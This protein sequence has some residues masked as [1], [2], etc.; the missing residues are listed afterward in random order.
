MEEG[1]EHLICKI[2]GYLSSRIQTAEQH[3][4]RHIRNYPVTIDLNLQDHCNR[5]PEFDDFQYNTE[6]ILGHM[7]EERV[8]SDH[9]QD[10]FEL[11]ADCESEVSDHSDQDTTSENNDVDS[12]ANEDEWEDI[13]DDFSPFKSKLSAILF[14]LLFG[15]KRRMSIQQ[16]K[17][18]WVIFDTAGILAPS[19]KSILK[20][21][22][23]I[24]IV[25]PV[26]RTTITGKEIFVRPLPDLIKRVFSNKVLSP[27]IQRAP[28]PSSNP[29]ETYESQAYSELAPKLSGV[30]N[31]IRIYAG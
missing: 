15:C 25:R 20:L 9:D 12:E 10:A 8:L 26:P 17:V 6:D 7:A 2:C 24:D 30:W 22:Q 21:R 23:T 28:N 19:L 3:K 11:T 13:Q 5:E 29:K 31:N 27:L 18:L 4:R 1:G 16:I 14:I